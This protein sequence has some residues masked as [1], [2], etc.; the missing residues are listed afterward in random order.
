MKEDIYIPKARETILGS[1][2]VLRNFGKIF[3]LNNNANIL[4]NFN[5]CTPKF[6]TA[7]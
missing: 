5:S 3:G 7:F 2:M 4:A 1:I 6:T